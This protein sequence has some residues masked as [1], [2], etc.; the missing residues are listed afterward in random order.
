MK[1]KEP[2]ITPDFMLETRS[3][4]HLY[5]QYAAELPIIDYHSHLSPA[6]LASNH[7][8]RSLTE[9]W[10]SCDHYKWRAMRANGIDERYITGDASDWEKFEK[11]AATVPYLLRNPLYHWTHLEL[12]RYF[13]ITDRLLSPATAKSIWDDANRRLEQAGFSARGLV[14]QSKVVLLCT[15]DDPTDSLEHHHALASDTGFPVKVLPTWRPDRGM[16]IEEPKAFNAWLDRLA[17]A[18]DIDIHDYNSYWEALRRRHDYF[19]AAGCRLSDHAMEMV[20][21]AEYSPEEIPRIFDKVRAGQRPSREETLKF[22]SAM[23]YELACL[24][25]SKGWTQ[26]FHIGAMRNNNSRMFTRLGPDSGFDAIADWPIAQPLARL[27]DRLD[28]AGQLPQTILYNLNPKDNA[29]LAALLGCFQDGSIPGKLQLGSAWWFLDQKDG[30]ERQLEDL[31][32]MGLLSRFVGMLTDSRSFLSFSRHEYFR[33]ILCNL[34]G[35]EMEQGLL[36]R[37]MFLV[38]RLVRD[39]CYGNA[40]R[41]FGFDVPTLP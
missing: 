2:F 19:A 20:Y 22:K 18:A 32:Q 10:L 26:Q 33:R 25:Y 11:W 15:T 34:L 29:V 8:F 12:A 28:S 21:A 14:L 31:S 6:Q 9:L 30:I 39:V 35:R 36:P 23:L 16:A 24:D 27:L 41:Y 38:S 17:A 5:H 40:A 3:A 7:R 13:G 37:D 1:L 4:R